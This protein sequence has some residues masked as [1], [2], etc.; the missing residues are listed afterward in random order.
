MYQLS[1]P[2]V[3]VPCRVGTQSS[4]ST[5]SGSYSHQSV[6]HMILYPGTPSLDLRVVRVTKDL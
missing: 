6:E 2:K 4:G 3:I 1:R 5:T